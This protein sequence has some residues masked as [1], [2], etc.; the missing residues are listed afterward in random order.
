M[1]EVAPKLGAANPVAPRKVCVVG[2]TGHKHVTCVGWDDTDSINLVDF[3]CVLV[4][5]ETLSHRYNPSFGRVRQPLSRLLASGGL[6]IVLG[7]KAKRLESQETTVYTNY[8]WSPIRISQHFESGN[9]IE[10]KVNMFP[11]LFS[12]FK[13][14]NFYYEVPW[15]WSSE[16]IKDLNLNDIKMKQNV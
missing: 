16:I 3:D 10:I 9:T 2:S 12:H 15:N 11:K 14:W 7:D 1:A 4:V 13:R 5:V 8:I 6:V